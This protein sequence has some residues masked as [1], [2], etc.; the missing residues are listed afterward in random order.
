MGR[1]K[2]RLMICLLHHRKHIHC[3]VVCCFFSISLGKRKSCCCVANDLKNQNA[4][5]QIHC[6][7]FWVNGALI[8][9]RGRSRF[10]NELLFIFLTGHPHPKKQTLNPL[11]L[12]AHISFA[13]GAWCERYHRNLFLNTC[14][15]HRLSAWLRRIWNRNTSDII[16]YLIKMPR[17]S[18]ESGCDGIE[19]TNLAFYLLSSPTTTKKNDLYSPN[20]IN[21]VHT[22]LP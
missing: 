5:R 13:T 14:P 3:V 15:H 4:L 22:F 18:S 19:N 16:C 1:N 21:F 2:N 8:R 9:L 10:D 20:L 7:Y 17:D 12:N 6:A 11:D